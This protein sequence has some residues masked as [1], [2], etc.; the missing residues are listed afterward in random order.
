M[1]S[2]SFG[3]ALPP[4]KQSESWKGAHINKA[5][6]DSFNSAQRLILSK[7]KACARDSALWNRVSF[8]ECPTWGKKL[9][10]EP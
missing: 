7:I 3:R 1:E 8:L 9:E 4:Q 10:L 2:R 5:H 6:T